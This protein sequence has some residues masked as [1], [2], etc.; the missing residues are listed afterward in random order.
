VHQRK[1]QPSA[2][3]IVDRLQAQR[4]R[5]LDAVDGAPTDD[6]PWSE[7][8]GDDSEG[9]IVED[10]GEVEQEVDDIVTDVEEIERV[11][12]KVTFKVR[13][14]A[15][16]EGFRHVLLNL[17][18]YSSAVF[19]SLGLYMMCFRHRDT[20]PGQDFRYGICDCTGDSRVCIC[21]MCCPAIRWADTVSDGK[22]GFILFSTALLLMTGLGILSAAPTLGL[23]AWIAIVTIGVH[24]RQQIR[25]KYG[26]ET[27]TTSSYV[28][29]ISVWCCCTLCAICQ[30]ARQVDD[31]AEADA[32]QSIMSQEPTYHA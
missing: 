6:N 15:R 14:F 17:V 30:E 11:V 10:S 13:R 7:L 2:K 24:Y 27:E 8:F 1:R 29:D 25:L 12:G 32:R 5:Q 21:G 19:I 26:L 3:T 16:D 18:V 20:N 4:E 23:L 22:G 28:E 9:K 31:E